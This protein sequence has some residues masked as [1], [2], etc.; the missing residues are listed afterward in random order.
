MT[1]GQWEFQL[2]T[3]E[4]INMGDQLWVARYLLHRVAEQFGVSVT[5][6]PKPTVNFEPLIRSDDFVPGHLWR[7]EWRWLPLQLLL[8]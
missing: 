6:H 2:G 8:S 5:F 4:G 1:P 3:C 7:L